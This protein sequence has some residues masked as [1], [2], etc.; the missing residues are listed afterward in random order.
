MNTGENVNSNEVFETANIIV[1]GI[2]GA[3]KSTLINA[4]FGEDFAETGKG[5]PI[6]QEIKEY[7]KEG[8]PIRIWDS[9]GF[10]IGSNS[11]GKSKTKESIA[12]IKSTIAEQESKADIDRIHAIWYC[13]NQGGNRYQS[14]EADF[15]KE[16]HKIG[17]PFIIIVTQCINEDKEFVDEIDKQNRQ[18]G[19]TDI[20]VIEVLAQDKIMRGGFKIP[21]FGLDELVN[22][23]MDKLPSFIKTSFIA[24]QQISVE[25]KREECECIILEYEKKALK[26]FRNNIPIYN[27]ILANGEFKS[28]FEKIFG[29]YNQYLPGEKLD[30]CIKEVN[31]QYGNNQFK[32]F[33]VF[34]LF[35]EKNKKRYKDLLDDIQKNGKK[36]LS[37]EVKDYNDSNTVARIIVFYGYTL[38][39]AIEEVW[40]ECR[41]SQINN[42]EVKL[43]EK[44]KEILEK[45][46]NRGKLH[47]T[48]CPRL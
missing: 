44:I 24:A 10:E 43:K 40:K 17:V 6:T 23:T 26:D 38:M 18:N 34:D 28:M 41:E 5:R 12:K 27:Q 20:P 4:V 15:V 16:L 48:L 22:I 35:S 7:R 39:L 19:I 30:E 14:T 11:D 1:A 37:L 46:K 21:A 29:I 3:G 47:N 42:L 36:G 25:L 9:I 45:Y 2:T 13:I 8:I 32:W 31:K 33:F